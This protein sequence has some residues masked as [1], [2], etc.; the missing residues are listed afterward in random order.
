[1]NEN[2]PKL[3]NTNELVKMRKNNNDYISKNIKLTGKTKTEII[4]ILGNKYVEDSEGN[5]IYSV[6]MF[7]FRRKKTFIGF[8]ENDIADVVLIK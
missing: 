4:S 7:L 1:M 5:I 6:R 2:C 8:D 3:F